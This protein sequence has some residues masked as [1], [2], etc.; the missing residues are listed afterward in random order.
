MLGGGDAAEKKVE[1]IAVGAGSRLAT[2]DL[3]ALPPAE[4]GR[5]RGGG[6]GG[7]V[8]A[9][10]VAQAKL[11]TG[12]VGDAGIPLSDHRAQAPQRRPSRGY[13]L[14]PEPGQL[15]C[16]PLQRPHRL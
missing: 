8:D 6:V 2:R 7:V 14:S 13:Q 16:P 9:G 15:E 10:C 11:L 12:G 4:L 1:V 3:L 5:D